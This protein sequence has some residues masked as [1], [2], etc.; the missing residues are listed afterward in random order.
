M[1]QLGGIQVICPILF[2]NVVYFRFLLPWSHAP[3]TTGVA[4]RIS[5]AFAFAC[6]VMQLP[7]KV[8]RNFHIWEAILLRGKPYYLFIFAFVAFYC[9]SLIVG[10][11]L[12][13]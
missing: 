9:C 5:P 11:S 8:F 7:L 3:V 10:C 12:D 6:E 2:P 4:I 13:C 1:S